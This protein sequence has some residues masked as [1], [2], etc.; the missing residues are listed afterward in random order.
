MARRVYDRNLESR[1]SRRRLTVR[2]KPYWKGIGRGLHLGYRKGKNGGVWVIRRYLGDQAYVLKT[3]AQADDGE[4]ANGI[5]IL[6]F[7]Q[8]QEA[9]R[10]IRKNVGPKIGPYTVRDAVAAYLDHLEDRPSYNDTKKRLEAFVLP[11]FGDKAVADLED[12]EVRKWHR[13]IA[14]TPARRRSKPGVVAH[15]EGDLKDPEVARKRQ[16]SANRC[17]ALLKAALNHAWRNAKKTGVESNDA[18]QRVQLF[19]GVDIGRARYLELSEAQRLIAAA[20]GDF[21]ALVH[22]ALQTGARYSELARLR[23]SD[24]NPEAG[25]LH[26]IKSKAN[27]DRHIVLTDEGIEFFKQ[28]ALGRSAS[29]PLLGHE[30]GRGHQDP[31]MK[32]ASARAG[33]DPPLNF[34]AL[35]HTWASL[36]VMAGMPLMVV[37]KNLGHSDTRMVEKH[38]GHLAPSYIADAIRANAPH[39]GAFKPSNIKSLEPGQPSGKKRMVRT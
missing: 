17:L 28:L 1:D 3:I 23:V 32:E 9:A 34:H 12:D 30:W 26:I 21:R 15:R 20:R 38:Y 10:N 37:A 29:A 16:A 6:D 19:R 31:P 24:F 22:A 8:A 33:I 2:G 13:E 7:W 36:S 39:F 27:K 11:I 14:R 25:T 4:D 5:N 18:W 35:R